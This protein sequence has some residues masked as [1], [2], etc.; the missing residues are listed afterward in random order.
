MSLSYSVREQLPA[1][2]RAATGKTPLAGW[3]GR[4]VQWF[5][6]RRQWRDL[7]ERDDR[8]LAD[9][10]ISPEQAYRSAGRPL[11]T[12]SLLGLDQATGP[13]QRS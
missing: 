11:Q 13:N 9:V 2:G 10:G 12:E 6:R 3:I 7:R 8:L 5:A 1:A 4:V